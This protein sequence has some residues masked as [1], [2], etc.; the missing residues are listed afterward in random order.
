MYVRYQV[1]VTVELPGRAKPHVRESAYQNVCKLMKKPVEQIPGVIG[2]G[3]LT[4]VV[5]KTTVVKPR[6]IQ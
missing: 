2:W 1:I 4:H 3:V 5:D 6:E